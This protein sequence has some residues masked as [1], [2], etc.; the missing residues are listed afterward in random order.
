MNEKRIEFSDAGKTDEGQKTPE[1]A[2]GNPEPA[3]TS[4]NRRKKAK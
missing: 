4:S 1:D 2:D 3:P